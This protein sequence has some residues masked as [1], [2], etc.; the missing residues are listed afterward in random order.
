MMMPYLKVKQEQAVLFLELDE[1]KSQYKK[2]HP[3]NFER[4]YEI[5][6]E[7]QRLKG[8]SSRSK[9]KRPKLK[10]NPY[11]PEVGRDERGRFVSRTGY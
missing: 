3:H 5:M 8:K 1:I 2:G 10:A 7:V 6:E 4:Q 11:V 9:F